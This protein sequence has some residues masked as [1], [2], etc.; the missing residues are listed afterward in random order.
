MSTEKTHHRERS[1][2]AIPGH[3][4]FKHTAKPAS[5]KAILGAYGLK[6]ADYE[7]VKELVTSDLSR[8]T[9]HAR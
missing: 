3:G 5:L 2:K 4:N 9:V 6:Q 7:R 1:T 8:A